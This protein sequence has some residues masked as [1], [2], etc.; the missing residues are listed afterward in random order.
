MRKLS[1]YIISSTSYYDTREKHIK[2]IRDEIDTLNKKIESLNNGIDKFD[3]ML[4][5]LVGTIGKIMDANIGRVNY[6]KKYIGTEKNIQIE[7]TIDP[8]IT[9]DKVKKAVD[10]LKNTKNITKVE[11]HSKIITI[12]VKTITSYIP[13]LK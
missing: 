11:L 5:L 8:Q 6:E 13:K 1:K 4:T 7:Y 3:D 2:P 9:D 12:T 10:D